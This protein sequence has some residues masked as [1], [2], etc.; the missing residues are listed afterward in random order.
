MEIP[1][2]IREVRAGLPPLLNN[3][4]RPRIG[5]AAVAKKAIAP[6]ETIAHGVGSFL[7]RGEAVRFADAPRHVPIGL[8]RNATVT[9]AIEPGQMLELN[10]VDLPASY[11]RD[12]GLALLS[13][14]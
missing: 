13:G 7:L 10:D 6:G 12:I 8:I 4:A 2:T 14:A 5:V 9:R 3:S 1:K 11:G